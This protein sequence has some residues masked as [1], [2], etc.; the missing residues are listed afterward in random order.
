MLHVV[1]KMN[2]EKYYQMLNNWDTFVFLQ[3]VQRN[4]LT[5]SL[6]ISA[7]MECI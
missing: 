7:K 6:Y 1:L 2:Y 4:C 5:P 3:V